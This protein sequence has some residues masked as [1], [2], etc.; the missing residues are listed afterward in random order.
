MTSCRTRRVHVVVGWS[1]AF[2]KPDATALGSLGLLYRH[3]TPRHSQRPTYRIWNRLNAFNFLGP[4]LGRARDPCTLGAYP[5]H[6]ARDNFQR[7]PHS[8]SS[9]FMASWVLQRAARE[10]GSRESVGWAGILPPQ[11]RFLAVHLSFFLGASPPYRVISRDPDKV[12]GH[13]P[14]TRTVPPSGCPWAASH[15]SNTQ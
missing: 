12:T 3:D 1:F 11:R 7:F 5:S 14:E 13:R 6:E 8:P 9:G 10:Q 2:H 4:S 15:T